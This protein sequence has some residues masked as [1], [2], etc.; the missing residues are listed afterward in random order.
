M[1]EFQLDHA[2]GKYS[3]TST[4]EVAERRS[5]TV[6]MCEIISYVHQLVANCVCLLS[7]VE[8]VV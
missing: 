5:T 2:N 1:Y 4:G 3:I 6:A 7:G 8:Q